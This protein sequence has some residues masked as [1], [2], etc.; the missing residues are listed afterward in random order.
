M[1]TRRR[2]L[3]TSAMAGASLFSRS[4]LIPR[5]ALV[6]DNFSDMISIDMLCTSPEIAESAIK[7]LVAAGMTAAVFDIPL[8]PREHDGAIREF[9]RLD[10]F[11][12]EAVWP[13]TR[14]LNSADLA[15][16]KKSGKVGIILA[17]Q[18]ASI[19]GPASGDFTANLKTFYELGLRVLQLT[20]NDRTPYGDSFMESRDGGLS[21]AGRELTSNMNA[22]GVMIDLS[23]C[24]RLTLLDAVAASSKPCV[25]THAGCK[26]LAATARNKSDEEIKAVA[27]RGGVFGVYDMTTWLTD[28]PSASLDTVLDHIDHVAHL[29]GPEHVGFGSDGA[30]DQ[31]DA[32]A[33]VKRMSPVQANHAGGPSFEWPVRQVRVPELNSPS[34]LHALAEGL[35]KRGYS[36]SEI[37]GIVGGNFARLFQTVCG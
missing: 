2:L 12:R 35:A 29:V 19:L 17:C 9:T 7:N 36:F 28:K 22:T 31:L 14:V 33:E 27:N 10:K 30:L 18:D 20:H 4:H 3:Q 21:N 5:K 8:Y 11:F 23:H 1:I 32:D 24:S 37:S 15:H 13:V 34:R 6:P 26:E 16:A 25:V